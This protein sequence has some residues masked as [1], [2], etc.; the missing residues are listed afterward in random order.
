MTPHEQEQ[1]R[2]MNIALNQWAFQRRRPR[3]L[4]YAAALIEAARC[5]LRY[6]AFG[7]YGRAEK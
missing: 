5:R 4:S 7:T 6:R 2:Q 3:R 1:L